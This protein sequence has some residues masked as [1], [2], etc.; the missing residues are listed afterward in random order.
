MREGNGRP[1]QG[2]RIQAIVTLIVVV[3][4]DLRRR[5]GGPL[6]INAPFLRRGALL[7]ERM[8]TEGPPT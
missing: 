2:D 8:Q 4:A 5:N 7:P 1:S 6:W 3:G